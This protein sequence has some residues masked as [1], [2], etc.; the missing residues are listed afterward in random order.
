MW[1]LSSTPAIWQ[2]SIVL[3]QVC[4]ANNYVALLILLL[5]FNLQSCV[6]AICVIGQS[7]SKKLLRTL[8]LLALV[9]LKF[10]VSHS[11]L[12]LFFTF[13]LSLIPIF[14]IIMGWGYQTERLVAG[15]ALFLYTALG[16]IPLLVIILI[17]LSEG[18]RASRV[19]ERSQVNNFLSV[20]RI[21]L[22]GFIVKLPITGVHMWLPKAHVEA[23]VVGSMFLAAILLKLGG[24]GVVMFEQFLDFRWVSSL[25]ASLS[26][27]GLVWISLIC[28]Q[29]VDSKVLIAFSSVSHI[30]LV[31]AASAAGTLLSLQC[32]LRVLISHGFSSSVGFLIVFLFYL[33]QNRRRLIIIKTLLSSS[34]LLRAV[35]LFTVLAIVGCPPSSNLWREIICYIIFNVILGRAS[36][37]LFVAALLAGVYGFLL[38][39]KTY[40]GSD[41]NFKVSLNISSFE[42]T[43]GVINSVATIIFTWAL[44][45]IFL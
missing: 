24:W 39:G 41:L 36:K 37:S 32:G 5:V 8:Y 22:V 42:L 44:I 12:F 10:F 23:P 1:L 19:V 45:L 4:W 17:F 11:L 43:Q 21:A 9:S 28:V 29:S 38:I 31:L 15:K 3:T 40:S 6:V 35:W 13:E 33:R 20:W 27:T 18:I 2:S 14:I 30:G 34:G 26:L 7:Y 16:S 25:I